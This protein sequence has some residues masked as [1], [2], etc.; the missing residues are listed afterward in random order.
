MII[1][2]TSLSSLFRVRFYISCFFLLFYFAISRTIWNVFTLF[3]LRAL[4]WAEIFSGYATDLDGIILLPF[5]Q[6][7][8][9][10]QWGPGNHSRGALSQ[11]PYVLRARH[12]EGQN[13]GRGV[14]GPQHPTRGLVVSSSSGV[15]DGAPAENGFYA[16]LRSERSHLDHHF[17]YFWVMAGPPKCCRAREN[18]PSF[19]PSRRVCLYNTN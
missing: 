10:P 18:F 6:A 3:T 14:S 2:H 19:P 16:Y 17:Q 13:V 4:C 1:L 9:E 5:M 15:Q 12:R 7:H 11:F 8:R